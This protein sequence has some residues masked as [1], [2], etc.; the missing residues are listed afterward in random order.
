MNDGVIVTIS[1]RI[2]VASRDAD[3]ILKV[4]LCAT[5]GINNMCK[6]ECTDICLFW[7]RRV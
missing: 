1:S 3:T 5:D 6:I 2:Y 4:E 7:C